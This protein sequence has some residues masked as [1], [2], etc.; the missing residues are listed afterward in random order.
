MLSEDITK[1]GLDGR[2]SGERGLM[3]SSG[4]VCSEGQVSSVGDGG[5]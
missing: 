4:I 3:C 1:R 2:V 5:S